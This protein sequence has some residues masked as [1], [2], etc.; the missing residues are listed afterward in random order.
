MM[1]DLLEGLTDTDHYL[2]V[3]RCREKLSE[4]KQATEKFDVQNPRQMERIWTMQDVKLVELS[5]EGKKN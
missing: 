5:W 4:S 3:A 1:F 2:V